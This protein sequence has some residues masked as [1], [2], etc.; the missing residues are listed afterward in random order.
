MPASLTL[1]EKAQVERVCQ[2]G[3][4]NLLAFTMAFDRRY[5][6]E[7]VHR[8]IAEK[9]MEVEAG[10]KKRLIL[11]TPP[12][13]GKSRLASVELPTWKLGR[14]PRGQVIVTSYAGNLPKKHS[15]EARN[16][17]LQPLWREMFPACQ[18][19]VRS[20]GAEEWATVD[21]GIYKAVG[22]EGG[23]TGFG[24]DL[25][26]IDDPF[27]DHMEAHSPTARDKVWDWYL[28]TAFTRL[29]PGGAVIIIMTRWHVD[30]L[31]GRLLDPKRQQEVEDLGVDVEEQWEVI[32]LPAIAHDKDPL[33][34]SVGEALSPHRW[35]LKRL[36]STRA[37]LG[38]YL[39][40]ALYDGN[41][42]P[43]GGNYLDARKLQ[44][45]SAE[46]VPADLHWMRFWDLATSKKT[47]ADYTAS[48]KGAFGRPPEGLAP[49]DYD[50]KSKDCLYLRD[51]VYGQ[52]EWPKSKATIKEIA[53]REKVIVGI[54]AVGGFK[55]AYNEV[56][57]VVNSSVPMREYGEEKDK[58]SRALPWIAKAE[59]DR[60]FLVAGDWITAFKQQVEQFPAGA[61]D[62]MVDATSGVLKMLTS[63]GRILV[64]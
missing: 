53:E 1:R 36:L 57:A 10:R 6:A 29:S 21:G 54:E 12:R 50:G 22:I 39:W 32:N 37:V 59:A 2:L 24:C 31:V 56:R 51:M 28:S 7:P 47:M 58:L 25:L 35:P 17:L 43:K 30:D 16:R 11:N 13:H 15:R 49:K 40:S 55:V 5:Y 60:V 46:Q 34:R 27:K 42:V 52:W 64:A 19:N 26:I 41:P 20:A 14:N 18:L 33:G 9:F 48:V 38:T 45:I 61:N 8:F 23:L 4:E 44:V 62:D 3:R 63:G